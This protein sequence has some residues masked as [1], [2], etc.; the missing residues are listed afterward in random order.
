MIKG[1]YSVA[2]SVVVWLFLV[3]FFIGVVLVYNDVMPK[4]NGEMKLL[5]EG[6]PMIGNMIIFSF[7]LF[8]INI[9]AMIIGD[10]KDDFFQNNFENDVFLRNIIE[11]VLGFFAFSLLVV[12]PV[13]EFSF[14]TVKLLREYSIESGE[15]NLLIFV[16]ILAILYFIPFLIAKMRNHINMIPIFL[17][18]LLLG[19]TGIGWFVAF[20]WSFTSTTKNDS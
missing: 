20:I 18:T 7:L 6:I 15:I 19:W 1:S 4:E 13:M 16:F 5:I 17:T 10:F 2:S 12:M 14:Y 11:Y 9:F 3:G 8:V